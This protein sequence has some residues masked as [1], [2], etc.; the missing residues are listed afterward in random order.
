MLTD[1]F[2][3]GTKQ[4]TGTDIIPCNVFRILFP[5][6][7]LQLIKW[8]TV[9]LLLLP[10][11]RSTVTIMSHQIKIEMIDSAEDLANGTIKIF[12][13]AT[14]IIYLNV[15]AGTMSKV[16]RGDAI[17]NKQQNT[18]LL[19]LIVGA[20]FTTCLELQHWLFAIARFYVSSARL[21][22]T[23]ARFVLKR[24]YWRR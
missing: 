14:P 4:I 16:R 11:K 2:C 10:K 13:P 3:M 15:I 8:S 6:M 24:I 7:V 20:I 1:C 19:F 21:V 23:K 12:I 9:D 22:R 18:H 5:T 17:N